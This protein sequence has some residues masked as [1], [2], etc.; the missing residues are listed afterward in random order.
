MKFFKTQF[1]VVANLSELK[2]TLF[3]N[4]DYKLIFT[5]QSIENSGIKD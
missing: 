5:C 2:I 3:K 1:M 4:T